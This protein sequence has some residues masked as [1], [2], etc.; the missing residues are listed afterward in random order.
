MSTPDSPEHRKYLNR[1]DTVARIVVAATVVC[2]IVR[3]LTDHYVSENTYASGYYYGSK[4]LLWAAEISGI[5]IIPCLL[6]L[7][8]VS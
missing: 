8:G 7:I 3:L 5:G 4:I 1:V 2:V 6:A